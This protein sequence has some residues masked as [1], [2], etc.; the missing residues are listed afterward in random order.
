MVLFT[1]VINSN[2]LGRVTSKSK[3][4]NKMALYRT[5]AMIFTTILDLEARR[6]GKE[7]SLHKASKSLVSSN[8]HVSANLFNRAL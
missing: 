5:A 1:S 6:K 4:E 3:A 2:K 8:H 7:A